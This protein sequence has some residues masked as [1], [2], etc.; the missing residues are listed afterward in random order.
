[1]GNSIFE[2][3]WHLVAENHN[4]AR[5]NFRILQCQNVDVY[6]IKKT[7]EQVPHEGNIIF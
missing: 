7:R 2:V 6:L 3:N 1:M 5:T 4:T